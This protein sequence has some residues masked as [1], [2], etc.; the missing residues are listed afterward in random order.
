MLRPHHPS[1]HPSARKRGRDG[2]SLHRAQV[3]QSAE[4][5]ERIVDDGQPADRAQHD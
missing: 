4:V 3:W 5:L 2:Y 1:R